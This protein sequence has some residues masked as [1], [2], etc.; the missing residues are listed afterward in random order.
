MV[1]ATRRPY[2]SLCVLSYNRPRFLG[3]MLESLRQNAGHPFELI[4]HDDG[5]T[6]PELL[7]LL[8]A[9]HAEG[10]ISAL[11]LNAPGQNQGQ[12][13]ALNRMFQMATGDP[14]VKLDH[15]LTFTEDWLA[16][17]VAI[18]ERSK[19]QVERGESDTRIGLLGLF[20]YRHD[21]ADSAKTILSDHGFWQAHSVI[22]GSGFAMSRDVWERL[23]PFEEHSPAFGEDWLMQV[24][25]TRT[26][27]LACALPPEDLVVNH[28]FGIGPSTT[29]LEPGK[30]AEIHT[31]PRVYE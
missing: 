12:G 15:D 20:H 18:L 30:F 13:V 28:G 2:A 16:K 22:V 27:G 19:A 24:T 9:S 23:G 1:E 4:V 21:P 7:D 25:V 29:T 14:I 8:H 10:L 6:D 31:E 26:P 5:S 11:I 17:T 3:P